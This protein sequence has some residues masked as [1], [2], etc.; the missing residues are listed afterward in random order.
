[1]ILILLT[2]E[3]V[4]TGS[5]SWN[6]PSCSDC[7]LLWYWRGF[8][9]HLPPLLARGLEHCQDFYFLSSFPHFLFLPLSLFLLWL[10]S[11]LIVQVQN[12]RSSFVPLLTLLTLSLALPPCLAAPPISW[13]SLSRTYFFFLFLT[14]PFSHSAFSLC[15]FF[16]SVPFLAFCFFRPLFLP[17][18]VIYESTHALLRDPEGCWPALVL[19]VLFGAWTFLQRYLLHTLHNLLP[20]KPLPIP[21]SLLPT[22][23]HAL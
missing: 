19:Y 12:R 8:A 11:S 17:V 15:F 5:K 22:A 1:M 20:F 3:K 13:L 2:H 7:T 21:P 9:A 14:L 6:T 10:R 4:E 18:S 23:L 16:T